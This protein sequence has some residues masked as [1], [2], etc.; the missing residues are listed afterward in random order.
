[1]DAEPPLRQAGVAAWV[2]SR[3]CPTLICQL[4]TAAS[5]KDEIA[6]IDERLPRRSLGYIDEYATT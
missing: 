6:R 2:L 4:G 1:M 3:R 5:T